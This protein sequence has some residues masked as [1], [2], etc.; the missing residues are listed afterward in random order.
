MASTYTD[1]GIE[2]IGVGEQSNTWGQTT[3]TNWRLME[4]MVTG[5]VQINLNGLTSFNLTTTLRVQ[6]LR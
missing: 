2:L 4:E 6:P 5:V 3:N 1:A